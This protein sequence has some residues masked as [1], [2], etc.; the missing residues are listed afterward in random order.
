LHFSNFDR[1]PLELATFA[2]SVLSALFPSFTGTQ[3][4]TTT[5]SQPETR[6][7]KQRRK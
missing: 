4:W 2:S 5:T 3:F 6:L 1:W 7:W